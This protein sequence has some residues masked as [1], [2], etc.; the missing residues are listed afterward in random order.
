MGA[1]YHSDA[2]SKLGLGLVSYFPIPSYTTADIVL[3]SENAALNF[4]GE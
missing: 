1:T 3:L 2:P 4:K